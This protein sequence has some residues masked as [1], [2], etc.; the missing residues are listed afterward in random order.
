MH[1]LAFEDVVESEPVVGDSTYTA[2][3]AAGRPK[4]DDTPAQSVDA[5]DDPVVP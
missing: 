3:L 1:Q 4:I 5:E 2:W